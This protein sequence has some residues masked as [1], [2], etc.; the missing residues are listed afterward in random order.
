LTQLKQEVKGIFAALTTPFVN[1][2]ISPEK[3]KENIQRYNSF[4]LAGYVIL[5]STGEPLYLTE[6]ESA[7]IVQTGKESAAPEK[8]IIVGTAKES[9][10]LTIEFTNRMAAFEIDA[11][12][13]R[14]PSY[15]KSQLTHQALK[16]FYLTVAD[17]SKVPVLIYHIPRLTGIS[18]D[19]E[20]IDEL[21]QH[22]NIAGMKDSSGNLA[23]MSELVPRLKSEFDLLLGAASIILSGLSMGAKGGILALAAVAP[24]KCCEL[25]K[26]FLEGR[27]EEARRLQLELIPLNKALTQIMGIPAIKYALDAVGYFGGHP[28]LP[29]L[30]LEEPEKEK[31]NNILEKLGLLL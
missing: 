14:T 12:L 22:P 8:K 9:A 15:Y 27:I 2:E 31:I 28:R 1:Q 16:K 26:L 25:Y 30:P 29:L 6:A 5:G 10:K 18:V 7:R 21:S 19:V 3:F 4:D 11:A 24:G 13:V 17:K 20:L 23:F